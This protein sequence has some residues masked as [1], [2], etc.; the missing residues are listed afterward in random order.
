MNRQILISGYGSIGRRHAQVLSKIINK[1]DITILTKQKINNFQ[2]IN[3]INQLKKINPKYIVICN[4]TS[5]HIKKVKFIEKNFKNKLVLVE[6]PLFHKKFN[7]KTKK[8]KFFVGYNLRFN[9][10]IEFLKRKLKSQVIWNVNVFCGSYLPNWRKN[11]DYRK[12]YSSKSLGGGV[13]RDLSHEIDYV[14][15]LFGKIKIQ[16]SQ[17]EKLSNLQIQTEDFMN[18]IGRSKKVPFIQ[19][20]LCYFRKNSVRRILIDGKNISIE[21]DLNKKMVVMHEGNRKK[22]YNFKNSFRNQEFKKQHL[23][24]LK[25]KY[26]SNLC[27]FKEGKQIV[28]LINQIKNR[29]KKQ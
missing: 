18:L 9:P 6:K 21:A 1:K 27:S 15:W 11:I 2:T 16:H 25:K 7:I 26:H 17:T 28:S 23:A 13:V 5:D 20:T 3:S 22:I 24:I 29:S 4:P 8:N 12:S 10:I 19:I 14:Q